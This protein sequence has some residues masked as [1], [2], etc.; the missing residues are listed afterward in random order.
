MAKAI[1]SSDQDAVIS[2]IDIAAPPARVFQSLIDPKQVMRWWTSPECPI[3]SFVLEPRTGGRWRYDT[4][5]STLNVNGV[6]KFHCDGEVVDYDPPRAIA[7]TWTANWHDRPAQ[8][9][10]VRW[11]LEEHEGG[12]RVRVTHSGLTDLPIARKDYSGGWAGLLSELKNF[13][14]NRSK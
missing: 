4:K 9:I 6:T 2:E 3:E 7:Y 1:L 13:L 5:Q 14:E 8:P 12:T 11:E 10:L